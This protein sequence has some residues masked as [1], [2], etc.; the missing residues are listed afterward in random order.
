MFWYLKESN[1]NRFG[2]VTIT[3]RSQFDC[4]NASVSNLVMFI[5]LFKSMGLFRF[6]S[7]K[8]LVGLCSWLGGNKLSGTIPDMSEM[9]ELQ[10]L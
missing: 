4:T 2:W 7:Q 10:S 5:N 3:K 6:F 1:K 9:H 8:L